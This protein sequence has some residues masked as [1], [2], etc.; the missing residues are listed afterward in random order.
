MKPQNFVHE[1][2]RMCAHYKGECDQTGCELDKI[3]CYINGDT[4]DDDFAKM[5]DTVAKWSDNHPDINGEIS[6]DDLIA[7]LRSFAKQHPGFN[8]RIGAP[9]NRVTAKFKDIHLI[10]H[11]DIDTIVFDLE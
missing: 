5:Y 10:Y 7:V 2:N 8:I 1:L 6:P 9:G 3:G 11:N 4:K